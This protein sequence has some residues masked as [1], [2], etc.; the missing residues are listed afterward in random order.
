ALLGDLACLLRCG[1][2]RPLR[3]RLLCGHVMPPGTKHRRR[4]GAPS[5]VC[6]TTYIATYCMCQRKKCE[7]TRPNLTQKAKR[8]R[9]TCIELC[10]RAG[11]L[12]RARRNSPVFLET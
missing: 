1:L 4:R 3:L 8:L 12:R 7:P 11:T 10:G 2:T 6:C 5:Q 9:K